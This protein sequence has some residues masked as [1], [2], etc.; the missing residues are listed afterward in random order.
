MSRLIA[1]LCAGA[2]FGAGLTLAGMVNPLKVLNFLDFAGNWDPSLAL[3]MGSGLLITLVTFRFVLARPAPVLA[4]QFTLPTKL[5]IDPPLMIGSALFGIGWGL[6]GYCPGP[7]VAA[8][9]F[10]TLE[11][12]LFVGAMLAGSFLGKLFTR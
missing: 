6:A 1:A 4:D 10:G 2:L 8:L 5:N 11:P 7:A 12:W 3:V 9:S